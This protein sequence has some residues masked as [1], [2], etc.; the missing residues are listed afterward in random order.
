[1]TTNETHQESSDKGDESEAPSHKKG[2][3][4]AASNQLSRRSFFGRMGASTALAAATSAALPS[5]LLGETAK[6]DDGD[7]DADDPASR[8]ERSYRLRQKVA[9]AER[10]IPTPPHIPNGD[11]KLYPNFIGN[12]S[13][14][15]PHNSLGE[16]VPAAYQ[17]LLTACDTGK[18]SDFANIP[19]GGNAKFVDPQGGLAYDLEGT[20]SGQLT[21]PPA[22]KLASA[23]RAG[24]MVEDYWMALAR[25]VPFSQ[26]G[27]EPITAAAIV[28]LNTLSHF[29]GP[30]VSG[31]VTA[32]TLFRGVYPGELIGPYVSQFFLA[33]VTFGVL[34]VAQKFNAYVPNKDYQTTF[35]E[36]LAV[37]NGQG[38]F[39]PNAL[40]GGTT[41]IKNGRDLGAFGH[42]DIA[43]QAYLFAA[44]WLLT[45]GVPLN[46]GNPYL[47]SKNQTGG[48]TFG[49]QYITDLLGE[50]SNRALKA[51]FYQKWFVHRTLRPIAYGG[52]VHNTM[53]GMA[54]YPLGKEVL[55][56]QAV[57]QTFS[58]YGTYLLPAGFPEGNPQHPSYPE[59]HG[60]IA[61]A[62][63]TV[64]KAF[65]NESFVL[66]SPMVASDDGQSLLNYTGADAGQITVGG[67]LNKLADNVALGRNVAA[68]HWR[69][70]A[71]QAL[72]LGE[73]LAISVLRDQRPTYNEPFSGFT[74]T[75][76]DGTTITV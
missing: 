16:V 60:S 13:Q 18:P 10:D 50:V 38:P 64:L 71:A 17:A 20:D 55:N 46:S 11:E 62:C 9:L 65:F 57:D 34:T 33:P 6:A 58:K 4:T 66:P 75:K 31:K 45:H 69:S 26:Y 21:V 47:T 76:F 27:A 30:K 3:I 25:D 51:S 53:T 7:G 5:L 73:V 72:L 32:G 63:V 41:Y 12:Y 67:E 56:S 44:Q 28:E 40:T 8:R 70:D 54:D 15:L 59:A 14:G 39:Q 29:E 61:G 24:E 68:V 23:H 36:W 19:L 48:F 42:A 37:Q 49:S 35:A 1:M 2:V 22:P 52:L 74:F 43:F